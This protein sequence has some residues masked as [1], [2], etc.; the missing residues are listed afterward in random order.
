MTNKKAA[1]EMSIGTIVTIVLLVSVLVVGIFFIQRIRKTTEGVIDMTDA[2]LRD[3]INK[4][5][6]EDTSKKVVIYPQTREIS[7]KKGESDEIGFSI[8]NTDNSDGIF[9]YEVTVEEIA[10]DCELS[11]EEAGE[12][13][14]L[15]KKGDNIEIPSGDVLE[16]SIRVKFSIPETASLCNI[17]YGINIDKDG[18]TY[19][20]TIG[21]D[22]EIKAK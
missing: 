2:Q 15:G 11:E 5:F 21:F 22:V 8:R 9:S 7:I 4:L 6:S 16:D 1:M 13:I 12:L 10:S 3:Q 18:S 17:R 20:P 14:I 19:S